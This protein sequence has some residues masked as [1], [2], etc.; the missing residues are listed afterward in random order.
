MS[1]CKVLLSLHTFTSTALISSSP[2]L[3]CRVAITLL[4]SLDAALCSTVWSC[5]SFNYN[6]IINIIN[7]LC[8][9]NILT[10]F[11]HHALIR[12]TFL[13][14]TNLKRRLDLNRSNYY[15]GNLLQYTKIKFSLY[16]RFSI[17]YLY[18]TYMNV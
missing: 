16:F 13:F 4:A 9:E 14:G 11:S 2:S 10:V 8:V 18:F 12:P 5:L 1:S 3:L 17:I 7:G 15:D 6:I